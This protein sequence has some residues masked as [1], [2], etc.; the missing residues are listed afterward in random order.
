MVSHSTPSPQDELQALVR[1]WDARQRR[2]KLLRRLPRALIAAL[3][4]TVLAV[5]GLR[6]AALLTAAQII[7]LALLLIGG[8]ALLGVGRYLRPNEPLHVAYEFDRLF[9]T[10]ERVSTALEL[11]AGRIRTAPE[12]AGRQMADAAHSA[13]LIDVRAQLPYEVRIAEWLAVVGLL[14]V[15]VVLLL[16]PTRADAGGGVSAGG[17]AAIGQAADD[18]R[19]ITEDVATSTTLDGEQREKRQ[20]GRAGRFRERSGGAAGHGPGFP[21][22]RLSRGH[23]RSRAGFGGGSGRGHR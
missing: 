8:G 7:P 16:I 3:I 6:T 20:A 4:V 2:Q 21:T 5:L 12:I 13:R 1:R 10:Q 23:A 18:V 14:I 9:E 22:D 19:D 15:L 17:Q 11:A